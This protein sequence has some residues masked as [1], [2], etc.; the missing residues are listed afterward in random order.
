[1]HTIRCLGVI[2][3]RIRTGLPMSASLLGNRMKKHPK[4][5]RVAMPAPATKAMTSKVLNWGISTRDNPIRRLAIS[6]GGRIC[7]C[8]LQVMSLMS[9]YFSTP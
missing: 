5:L 9:C 6:Y 2:A 7:T 8:D 1:M 3:G 4:S